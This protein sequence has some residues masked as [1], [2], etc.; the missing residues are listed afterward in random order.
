M[1][2]Y[3]GAITRQPHSLPSVQLEPDHAPS[4][5]RTGMFLQI[6]LRSFGLTTRDQH[7]SFSFTILNHVTQIVTG[8]I[9]RVSLD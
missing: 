1:Q 2:L 3:L 4:K 6:S 7:W 9:D 5:I 8:T